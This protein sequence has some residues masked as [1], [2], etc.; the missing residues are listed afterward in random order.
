MRQHPLVVAQARIDAA[1]TAPAR[2]DGEA[3]RKGERSLI[4][5][6]GAQRF[7]AKRLIADSNLG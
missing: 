7:F 2:V 6:L 3:G 1:R 4:E 5:P